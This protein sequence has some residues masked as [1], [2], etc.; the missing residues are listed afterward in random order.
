MTTTTLTTGKDGE[1]VGHVTWTA[2][3]STVTV[4]VVLDG[5]IAPPTAWWRLTHP[6]QL[7]H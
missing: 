2:G 4:P 3:T 6:A 7:W 1:T 5:S